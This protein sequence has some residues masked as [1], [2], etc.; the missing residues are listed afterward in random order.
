[1]SNT[2]QAVNVKAR[3]AVGVFEYEGLAPFYFQCKIIGPGGGGRLWDEK[4]LNYALGRTSEEENI[5]QWRCLPLFQGYEIEHKDAHTDYPSEPKEILWK[6]KY[7]FML[8]TPLD[9][10]SAAKNPECKPGES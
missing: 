8:W 4:L 3:N 1:M 9:L 7:V 2:F 6:G 10:K 5:N